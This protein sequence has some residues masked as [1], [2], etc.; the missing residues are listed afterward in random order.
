MS[1]IGELQSTIIEYLN[2]FFIIFSMKIVFFYISDTLTCKIN[3]VKFVPR[4]IYNTTFSFN[5][6]CKFCESFIIK[7]NNNN[8]NKQ[9][10][11]NKTKYQH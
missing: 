9:T 7:K 10:E 3:I 2:C 8:N 6:N 4:S 5:S 11:Q 1:L